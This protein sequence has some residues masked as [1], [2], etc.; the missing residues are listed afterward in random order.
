MYD[1]TKKVLE[2]SRSDMEGTAETPSIEHLLN[3]S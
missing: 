2:E 1:Y 3:M